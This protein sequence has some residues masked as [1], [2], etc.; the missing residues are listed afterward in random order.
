MNIVGKGI[1]IVISDIDPN[2]FVFGSDKPIYD[3]GGVFSDVKTIAD[4]LRSGLKIAAIKEVRAQTGWGLREA[5]DYIDKYTNERG[6][7]N[8]QYNNNSSIVNNY[9]A[10]NFIKEHSLLPPT[11]LLDENEFKL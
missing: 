11:D 10:D 6:F 5:K 7:G 3:D 9:C 4:C 2:D 8:P 1:C